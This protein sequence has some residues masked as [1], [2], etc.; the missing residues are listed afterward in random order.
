MV[1]RFRWQGDYLSHRPSDRKGKEFPAYQANITAYTVAWLSSKC[2]GRVDFDRIW[3]QQDISK[4]LRAMI[5]KWVVKIDKELRDT[6]KA[7]MPSKW[8]KKEECWEAIRELPLAF[9]DPLPPE[10]E[11]PGA[12]RSTNS[13]KSAIRT[14]V[15]SREGPIGATKHRTTPRQ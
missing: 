5:E 12:R 14:Q 2:E 3:S 1:S 10:L 13:S 6:A 7:R 9:P 15:L 8:A 4:P 11:A